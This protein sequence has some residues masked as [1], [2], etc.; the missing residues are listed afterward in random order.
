MKITAL[1]TY[2]AR[3]AVGK[4]LGLHPISPPERTIRPWF[5]NL[6]DPKPDLLYIRLHGSPAVK[7]IWYDEIV[8]GV[9]LP[10]LRTED[11]EREDLSGCIVVTGSCFAIESDF[12]ASFMAAGARAFVGG[13]GANYASVSDRVVGPD[14]LARWMVVGL[15]QGWS[16]KTSLLLAKLAI[17][18]WSW[19]EADRDAL[20]FSMIEREE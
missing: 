16:L 13:E 2:R 6:V 17:L 11:I 1:C 5:H 14:R 15:K 19:R 20:T 4:A 10:A 9:F 7:D 18:P 3:V 12:P 8:K